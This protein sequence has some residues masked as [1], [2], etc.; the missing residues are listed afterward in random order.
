SPPSRQIQKNM[1]Y[2]IPRVSRKETRYSVHGRLATL[3]GGSRIIESG[4]V[5]IAGDSIQRIAN[6]TAGLPLAFKDSPEIRTNATIF[7]GLVD[8]HNHFAYNIRELWNIPGRFSN[9]DEWQKTSAYRDEV[10]S[11]CKAIANGAETAKALVRFVEAK[12][13]VAGITTGQ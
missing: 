6:E 8:L 4:Y 7:A 2:F 11:P 5:C 10:S 3:D 9:R 1:A 12:A 13:I